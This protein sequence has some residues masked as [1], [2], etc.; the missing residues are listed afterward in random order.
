[1]TTAFITDMKPEAVTDLA[2]GKV[3]QLPRYAVWT[4]ETGRPQVR[5]CSNDLAALKEKYSV[6][7]E[8]VLVVS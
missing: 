2:T 3:F 7:D 5:E 8:N 4:E 1:M 6:S